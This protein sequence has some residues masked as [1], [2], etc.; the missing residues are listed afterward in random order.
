MVRII[1]GDAA[2]RFD[3]ARCIKHD[4]SLP[5]GVGGYVFHLVTDQKPA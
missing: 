5:A 3:A 1:R 4:G 2:V